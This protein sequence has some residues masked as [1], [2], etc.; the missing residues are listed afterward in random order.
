MPF[1]LR[2]KCFHFRL[3]HRYKHEYALYLAKRAKNAFLSVENRYYMP[4]LIYVPIF[5]AHPY[6]LY[7]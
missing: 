7:G 1:C 6:N 2:L 5:K 3:R 4:S